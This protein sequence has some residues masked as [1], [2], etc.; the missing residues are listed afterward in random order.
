MAERDS[1]K[2]SLD[3]AAELSLH[4]LFKNSQ[5][6]KHA[7]LWTIFT[8]SNPRAAGTVLAYVNGYTDDPKIRDAI[9]TTVAKL[10]A[11][12]LP[13]SS[14]SPSARLEQVRQLSEQLN[15]EET[16]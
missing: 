9:L 4:D 14:Y 8:H 12:C 15:S 7:E 3:I 11:F 10:A 5:G 1:Q 13:D 6:P 2:T 16:V